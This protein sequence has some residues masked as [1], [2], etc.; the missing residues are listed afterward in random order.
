MYIIDLFKRLFQRNNWIVLVYILLNIVLCSLL[1]VGVG[2]LFDQV[3]TM[4]FRFEEFDYLGV[5]LECAGV[6][7]MLDLIV[8]TAALS[9]LGE[10]ICR[11][12]YKCRP[13]RR[14]DHLNFLETVYQE[15]F[16]KA[17]T[18]DAHLKDTI[19]VCIIESQET[20][21]FALGRN[22][23]AVT[24]GVMGMPQEKVKAL[25]AREFGHIS[26]KDGDFLYLLI[27]GGFTV[28]AWIWVV[29]IALYTCLAI[30]LFGMA[31]VYLVGLMFSLIMRVPL[32]L[33]PV[34]YLG[35]LLGQA[36]KLIP[37]PAKK[38][39]SLVHQLGKAMHV[40]WRKVGIDM[41]LGTRS[42]SELGADEFAFHCGYGD[43]LAELIAKDNLTNLSEGLFREIV[44]AYPENNVRIG[45]LQELG[46]GFS[47]Y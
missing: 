34:K 18:V 10:W 40:G 39:I 1:L 46:V 45:K 5:F 3:M 33:E 6:I 13:I 41:I 21:V 16:E 36:C 42:V 2:V 32:G 9:P 37:A 20:S 17:R 7:A 26:Q 27:A 43:A 15:V 47:V 8:L 23:L 28:S 38:L 14:V 31:V 44:R 29:R 25:F 19:N 35:E 11:I 4:Q 12:R 24:T 30:I 22:T